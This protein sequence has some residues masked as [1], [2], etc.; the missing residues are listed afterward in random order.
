VVVQSK[1]PTIQQTATLTIREEEVAIRTETTTE[2]ETAA[3]EEEVA[4][5]TITTVN[6]SIIHVNGSNHT[7]GHRTH[8]GDRR[9]NKHG[10]FH[11]ALTLLQIG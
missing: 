4:V 5:T 7:S 1:V 8:N 6:N 3:V 10:Q 9:D 11:L 2:A